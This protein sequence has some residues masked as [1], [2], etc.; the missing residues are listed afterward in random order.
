[1]FKNSKTA[2]STSSFITIIEKSPPRNQGCAVGFV[3]FEGVGEK[4]REGKKA[5]FV[6][7]TN[8]ALCRTMQ[9]YKKM[10]NFTKTP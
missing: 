6:I 9:K 3:R 4:G 8:F 2:K 10:K 7:L 5:V 1:L